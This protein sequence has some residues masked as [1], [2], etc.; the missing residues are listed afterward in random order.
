MPK[1]ASPGKLDASS[2]RQINFFIQFDAFIFD[3]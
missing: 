1:K 2:E 3:N